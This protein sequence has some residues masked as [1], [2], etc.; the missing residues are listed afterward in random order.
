MGS[1][2]FP[3][4]HQHLLPS[5]GVQLELRGT[6]TEFWRGRA[7]AFTAA[8]QDQCHGCGLGS[9]FLLP[10]SLLEEKHPSNRNAKGRF[11]AR[12]NLQPE[13]L[14]SWLGLKGWK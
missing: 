3:S 8:G 10:R 11:S 13:L 2:S 12:S 5:L 1:H 7:N 4:R 9:V 6:G 14:S